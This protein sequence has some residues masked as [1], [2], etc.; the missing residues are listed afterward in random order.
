M[1]VANILPNELSLLDNVAYN[2]KFLMIHPG[3]PGW[4][5]PLTTK[6]INDYSNYVI[7]ETGK[8]SGF[9][10][11]DIGFFHYVQPVRGLPALGIQGQLNIIEPYGMSLYERIYLAAQSL[12]IKN[13]TLA[14]YIIQIKFQG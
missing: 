7:A 9:V 14:K 6:N 13:H 2:V 5:G 12:G 8:T 1:A 11:K 3:F 10:I 4:R